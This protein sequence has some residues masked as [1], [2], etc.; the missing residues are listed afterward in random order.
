MFCTSV[1]Q[2]RSFLPSQEGSLTNEELEEVIT[3]IQQLWPECHMVR[4]SPW[5][6][7]SNGG[8]ERVNQTVQ[9]KLGTWMRDTQS[10]RWTVGCRIIMWRYNTQIHCTLGNVPYRLMFGQLSHVGISLLI[11]DPDLINALCT[12]AQLNRVIE[13]EG[14]VDAWDGKPHVDD[15]VADVF[16]DNMMGTPLNNVQEAAVDGEEVTV[17]AGEKVATINA[18]EVTGVNRDLF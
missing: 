3:E 8:V 10:R 2:R 12:E 4:G 17:D 1:R 13:Y 18:Q 6:S 16:F 5:H 9:A 15:T 11:L 14:M 7:E